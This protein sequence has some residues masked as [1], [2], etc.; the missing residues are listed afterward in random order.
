MWS[1]EM[2]TVDYGPCEIL[3]EQLGEIENKI[4]EMLMS[5]DSYLKS[6]K[7]V[8]GKISIF[9]E[10]FGH[11]SLKDFNGKEVDLKKAVKGF[12][13]W[14]NGQFICYIQTTNY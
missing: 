3:L 14:Y 8:N 10:Q 12:D 1:K 5:D 6:R 4:K 11:K 7:V 2:N 13:I 9:G